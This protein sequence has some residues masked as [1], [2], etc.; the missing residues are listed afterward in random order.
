MNLENRLGEVET[1]RRD[2]LHGLAPP[3]RGHINSNHVLGTHVPVESRP[4]HQRF[5]LKA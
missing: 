2:H 4:Q 3:N 1:N 5:G